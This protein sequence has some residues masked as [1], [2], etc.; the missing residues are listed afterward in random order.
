M[1]SNSCVGKINQKGEM[2]VRK[3]IPHWIVFLHNDG[4]YEIWK[5]YDD[6]H[7]WGA[8]TY[9]VI[10]YFDKYKEAQACVKKCKAAA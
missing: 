6:T 2:K 10:D 4:R 9:E 7:V 1:W 8:P 3:C 5:D